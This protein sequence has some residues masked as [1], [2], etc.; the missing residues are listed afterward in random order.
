[1]QSANAVRQCNPLQPRTS[2][3]AR[4]RSAANPLAECGMSS[5]PTIAQQ[6]GSI[7]A[8]RTGPP[9]TG[10]NANAAVASAPHGNSGNHS[11]IAAEVAGAAYTA[12]LPTYAV[13]WMI[14]L[15]AIYGM[16]Q[17][18]IK[19]GNDGISP[20]MQ[21]GLRSTGATVVIVAWMLAQ[22][23]SLKPSPGIV[24]PALLIGVLFALEFVGFYWGLALTSAA[25]ATILLYTAPFFV[26][27]GAH[28]LLRERLHRVQ[29]L[30]L[31]LAFAGVVL[32][33]AGRGS[34]AATDATMAGDL[35][36][37]G[38]GIA[39]AATTLVI[40]GTALRDEQPERSLLY[41][42]VISAL[43]LTG[44][45]LLMG[46]ELGEPGI[47][48]PTIATWL[49]LA[50]QILMVA[51]FGYLS[52]FV[53]IQRHSAARLSAFTFLTPLFGVLFAAMILGERL[54][55]SLLGAACFCA[56]GLWLI[57]RR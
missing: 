32:V 35:L 30:G 54:T 48:A 42:L 17:I 44:A 9:G 57:N 6:T 16:G 21:A 41:Q 2:T 19:I 45:S 52:W 56:T 7:A 25:R 15:C 33:I 11:G 20:L 8:T 29:W 34:T 13:L 47:F 10:S 31:L 55:P 39:W 3:V 24:L 50:Y 22:R 5:R 1:M 51:S 18:A 38:G 36:C 53:L 26:A 28:F 37:L 4:G 14:A 49:S 12:P 40:R 27:L 43:L 46:K 23:I